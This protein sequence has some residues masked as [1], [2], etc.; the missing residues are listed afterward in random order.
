MGTGMN[1]RVRTGYSVFA[2]GTGLVC[3]LEVT[4]GFELMIET[5][6]SERVLWIMM[7]EVTEPPLHFS[8][9]DRSSFSK[10]FYINP[11][12]SLPLVNVSPSPICL[13]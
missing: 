4:E 10:Q 5:D 9:L 2:G 6:R 8:F 3:F 13:R 7:K 11:S 12:Q 1:Q